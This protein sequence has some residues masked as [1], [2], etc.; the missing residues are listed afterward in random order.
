MP[1]TSS[2]PSLAGVPAASPDPA[3]TPPAAGRSRSLIS[4]ALAALETLRPY[5]WV[6]NVL[7]F[8][9]LAAAH[10]LGDWILLA[11]AGR[12][13]VAFTLCA[14]AVY[15]INDLRDTDADRLHPHKRNRPI[16]AGRL[17]PT[18]AAGLVPVL[19]AGAIFA[20]LPLGM[21]TGAA[22]GL[23][24][25]LMVAYSLRLKGIVL[26]DAFVLAAGYALRVIA[27][28]FAV[29]IRP[30]PRLLA[31]CVFLF[32][33]VALIKRYA[34][35]ALLRSQDGP[36]ARTRAYLVEDQECIMALGCSSGVLAVLVLVLYMS[37]GNAAQL[38]RRSELIWFTAILLLYWISHMWL[39]AHRARMTD[40]PLVFALKD[41]MS[42]VLILSMGAIAWLAV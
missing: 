4:T 29:D 33:S 25:A 21:R 11:A 30:S 38:Y 14:S 5:Q 31:F 13:W 34:E 20:V 9:P 39:M 41:A 18:I 8:V 24:F 12:A 22:L 23:Y 19:L 28:G 36:A 6:K 42:R 16:A 15:V 10:R 35:L 37:A 7:V 40:D 17:S 27:G 2:E 32:F 3:Q 1:S 26:L